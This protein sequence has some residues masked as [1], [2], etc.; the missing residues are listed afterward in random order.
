MINKKKT[1]DLYQRRLMK[2][3]TNGAVAFGKVNNFGSKHSK[4]K[5][6]FDDD[7]D[8]GN[9][10]DNDDEEQEGARKNRLGLKRRDGDDEG[11]ISDNSDEEEDVARKNR[12]ELERIGGDDE[13]TSGDDDFDNDDSEKDDDWKLEEIFSD[14]DENN[15]KEIEDFATEVPVPQELTHL[16]CLFNMRFL[17]MMRKMIIMKRRVDSVNPEKS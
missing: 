12:L 8:E 16:T 9:I 14:D 6:C 7:D 5:T 2:A 13:D 3:A 11:N 17:W 4:Q 15:T 1:Q 10:S